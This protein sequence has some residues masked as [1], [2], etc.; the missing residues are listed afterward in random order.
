MNKQDKCPRCGSPKP[1]LHPA[2]QSEGEVHIC[3]DE[4]H[5]VAESE[6]RT[7]AVEDIEAMQARLGNYHP[8]AVFG[9]QSGNP[10]AAV[11]HEL[12]AKRMALAQAYYDR[13]KDCPD[14]T[15]KRVTLAMLRDILEHMVFPSVGLSLEPAEVSETK[16][17]EDCPPD[18]YPTDATRCSECPRRRCVCTGLDADPAVLICEE[19]Q[20][21]SDGPCAECGHDEGCHLSIAELTAKTFRDDE[22]I[23]RRRSARL[24]KLR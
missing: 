13:L 23:M 21:T 8:G 4:F 22:E 19:Y 9:K 18:N 5:A 1:S 14:Y 3:P 2:I 17:C 20:D 12:Y 15:R 24:P 16:L 11:N 10:L 7:E 6:A